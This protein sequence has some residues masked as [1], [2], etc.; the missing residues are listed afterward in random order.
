[1]STILGANY[2]PDAVATTFDEAIETGKPIVTTLL[3]SP[4]E[5]EPLVVEPATK[6][7]KTLISL[8]VFS[9][10]NGVVSGISLASDRLMPAEAAAASIGGNAVLLGAAYLAVRESKRKPQ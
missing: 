2:D 5:A 9:L 8:G 6:L 7:E 10:A 4:E 1:M 3:D